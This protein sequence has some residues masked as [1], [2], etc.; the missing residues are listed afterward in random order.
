VA[1]IYGGNRKPSVIATAVMIE[2]L[3]RVLFARRKRDEEEERGQEGNEDGPKR[4]RRRGK[5]RAENLG[6]LRNGNVVVRVCMYVPGISASPLHQ[7]P[8]SA[9]HFFPALF[10]G[11]TFGNETS[12]RPF[13][14]HFARIAQ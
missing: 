11:L 7:P 9:S 4:R 8:L 12:P 10:I 13:V 6:S 2:R 3:G 1:A 14:G 5:G